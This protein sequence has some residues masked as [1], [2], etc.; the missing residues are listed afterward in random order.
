MAPGD[1]VR[2]LDNIQQAQGDSRSYRYLR[3]GNGLRILLVSDPDA[4]RA[5][6]ALQV[7]VGSR[8]E[9]ARYPGLAHLLEHALF[10]GSDRYP[11]VDEFHAFLSAHGG[12]YNAVTAFEN[13]S[14]F[15]AL[16]A[17]ALEPALERF[18][19]L[20]IA[21]LLL[22]ERITGEIQVVDAEYRSKLRSEEQR[23]LDVF[24]TQL[25]P[26]HPY[27]RFAVGSADTLKGAAAA[28][29][30]FHRRLY[31]AE[32]MTLAVMGTAS[33]PALEMLVLSKFRSL[34]AG[35][36]LQ[37][38]A[39]VPLFAPGTLPRRVYLEPVR[40]RRQLRMVFPVSSA[41]P[42]YRGA[43][44]RY[45]AELLGDEGEGSLLSY[46]KSE[47]LATALGA[48][49]GLQYGGGDATFD[50]NIQLTQAGLAAMQDVTAAVFGTLDKIRAAGVEQWRLD[51]RRRSAEIAWRFQEPYAAEREM[52]RLAHNLQ[53]Y[54]VQEVLRGDYL[55]EDFST[56]V[57]QAQ[58][59]FLVP[60]NCLQLV[61]ARGA[62]AQRTSVWYGVDYREERIAPAPRTPLQH[63]AAAAIRLPPPNPYLPRAPLRSLPPPGGDAAAVPQV[64]FDD[65]HL[66]L[67]HLQ[68]RDFPG[69]RAHSYFSLGFPGASDTPRQAALTALLSRVL[70][71]EWSEK[72][73]PAVQAGLRTALSASPR[74]LTL[75][76]HGFYHGQPQLLEQLTQVL[77]E[78]T[79]APERVE[80]ASETLLRNWRSAGRGAP[81]RRLLTDLGQALV[82]GHWSEARL[83]EA[84]A[85]VDAHELRPFAREAVASARIRGLVQGGME[86]QMA[87]QMAALAAALPTA[88]GVR[89]SVQVGRIDSGERWRWPQQLP[90]GDAAVLLYLQA[91][92]DS[93]RSRALT[94]L[95]ARIL[96]IDFFRQLRVEQQLGYVV[97]TTYY[98]LLGVPGIVF[99]LQSPT[100]SAA[101]LEQALESFLKDA[102]SQR[103]RF[104]PP[105]FKQHSRAFLEQLRQGPASGAA[106]AARSWQAIA[107]G[108]WEFDQHQD[109][110]R[111][112]EAASWE[113]WQDFLHALIAPG[114]RRELL[115]HAAAAPAAAVARDAAAGGLRFVDS[116]QAM[117]QALSS[118][119][120]R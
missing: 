117:W 54:T 115:L 112:V 57:L 22:P 19:R 116:P 67:W 109:M 31:T 90:H 78:P 113:D 56:E 72:V 16:Q 46:L 6:A 81:Y 5:A 40:E 47:G 34:P 98:P 102:A 52:H 107:L 79:L 45:I 53:K 14:Y 42:A 20:F 62:A 71:D 70:E 68:E 96:S 93:E 106:A 17:S 99:A 60:D 91:A 65:E 12:V 37:E 66:Q 88:P 13:T 2:R 18:A 58:L 48:G 51:E 100:A 104:A 10:L 27:T 94:A 64:I 32:R 7:A 110:I 119:Y 11:D 50:V 87:L 63:G 97:F 41:S 44:L 35:E 89:P 59:A 28:A 29:P 61:S 24:R 1:P 69:P 26:A 95:C 101:Q 84:L 77:R 38:E 82:R 114:Q 76:L 4:P 55:T 15:F 43:P 9:P 73:W 120:S 21:P 25:N 80:I 85:A 33:L 92:D 49:P 108:D 118:W 39:E 111:A 23:L 83:A 36:E 86:P 105:L 3:L 30:A 8:D 103:S 75:E 74:G